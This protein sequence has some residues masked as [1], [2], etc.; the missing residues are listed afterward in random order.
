MTV[1]VE[2]RSLG[3]AVL[4]NKFA[5]SEIL[6]EG[7]GYAAF[8]HLKPLVRGGFEFGETEEVA[9][10]DDD[11][12]GVGEFVGD[13]AHFERDL[14]G[15]GLLRCGGLG[16]WMCLVPVSDEGRSPFDSKSVTRPAVELEMRNK[17]WYT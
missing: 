2:G 15:D 16:H 12:E 10:L 9:G 4:L 6:F 17:L 1:A 11:F 7:F 14:F 13:A 8:E 5:Q 3:V